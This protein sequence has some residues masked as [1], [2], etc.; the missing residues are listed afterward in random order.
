MRAMRTSGRIAAIVALI[1]VAW[2]ALWPL[3]SAAYAQAAGE[4]MPLCHMA[5]MMVAPGEM[6]AA[7]EAPAA[8][9]H[10]HDGSGTHCPL[11]IMAFYGAFHPA[12]QPT[13]FT[14]STGFVTLEAHCAPI[15]FG[16]E[17][18]LPESRAPP[19]AAM[20]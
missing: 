8:P 7:P 17:T 19:T 9:G 20:R 5:G 2:A 18:R 11:C 3:V 1:G 15:P 12:P 6:P 10:H 4:E 16:V 14:F 13:P